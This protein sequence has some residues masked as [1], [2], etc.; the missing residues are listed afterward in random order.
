MYLDPVADA[1]AH[2]SAQDASQE[3]QRQAE[4]VAIT[5]FM[6]ACQRLD[7]NALADFAPMTTDWDSVR[8]TPRAV[9]APMPKRMQTLAECMTDSLD[10]GNGPSTTEVM[11]LVLILAFSSDAQANQSRRARQLLASMANNWAENNVV[12]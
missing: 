6:K 9:G 1:D 8:A 2:S 12:G 7:A 5:D 4:A 3:A 11:Q 10:L